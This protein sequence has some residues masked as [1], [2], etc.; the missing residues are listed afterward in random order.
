MK[1]EKFE[2]SNLDCSPRSFLLADFL[3]AGKCQCAE[4]IC[5]GLHFKETEDLF[6][7]QDI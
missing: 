6:V 4:T 5:C 3:R 7:L 2:F 1:K